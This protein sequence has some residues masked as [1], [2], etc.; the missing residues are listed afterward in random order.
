MVPKSSRLLEEFCSMERGY[1]GWS[2]RMSPL[3]FLS[4]HMIEW[5]TDEIGMYLSYTRHVPMWGMSTSLFNLQGLMIDLKSQRRWTFITPPLPSFSIDTHL[6]S[7]G[8]KHG[9]HSTAYDF[10]KVIIIHFSLC[11]THV[12]CYSPI[13]TSLIGRRATRSRSSFTFI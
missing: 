1:R 2:T 12:S 3:P 9:F 10:D 11:C 8:C 13:S 6:I 5:I 4:S 7:S